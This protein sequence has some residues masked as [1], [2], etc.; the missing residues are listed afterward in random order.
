M[1]ENWLSNRVF[2]S[3]EQIANLCCDARTRPG[4]LQYEV[5][6]RGVLQFLPV[7]VP[8]VSLADEHGRRW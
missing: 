8:D 6:P 5:Q 4:R 2:K 1:R 7:G 3:Y